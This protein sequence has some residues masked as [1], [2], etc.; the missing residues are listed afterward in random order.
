LVD[1]KVALDP[2]T[3][4]LYSNEIRGRIPMS[5]KQLEHHS[6]GIFK[7]NMWDFEMSNISKDM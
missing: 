4:R 7:C 1:Y 6:K 5:E 2:L 3:G